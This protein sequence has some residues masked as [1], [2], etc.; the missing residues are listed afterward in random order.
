MNENAQAMVMASLAADS[1]ALGVHWI[2]DTQVLESDFGL[3]DRLLPPKPGSYHSTKKKGEFTHYGDQ[4]LVLLKSVAHS[5][6]F[7]PNDFFD[8]WQELFR[9]YNGYIDGATRATLENIAQGKGP[10]NSGSGSDDI[11][12]ASRIP[13]LVLSLGDD[14]DQLIEAV[15]AQTIMTHNDPDTI[16]S[17]AFFALVSLECLG[18]AAPSKAVLGIAETRFK[19]SPIAQW[20]RQGLEAA[21]EDSVTAVGR[22]GQS[23]HTGDAFA[24]IIQIIARYEENLSQGIV[25]A[26]MAGGDNAARASLVAMI[27]A[28][29]RGM[30][31]K[32]REWFQGLEQKETILQCLDRLS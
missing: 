12:P 17:A 11:A 4:S 24:G 8:L 27:L 6:G 18:G 9:E 32:T 5:G 14:P 28:S 3:V 13:S 23:C 21:A 29:A 1:L 22:L 7:D 25:A 2:Y 31:T 19:D 10:Y 15:R 20:T 16:D 26:V 30:D